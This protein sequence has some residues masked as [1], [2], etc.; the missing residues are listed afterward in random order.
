[1]GA[2]STHSRSGPPASTLTFCND[3][4]LGEL[5]KSTHSYLQD[6]PYERAGSARERTLDVYVYCA[7]AA[8]TASLVRGGY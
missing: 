2:E 5:V 3:H 6:R 8:L 7:L 4:S 1:M